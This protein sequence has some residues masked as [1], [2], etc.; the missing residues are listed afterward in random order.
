M[1][2]QR[3]VLV[4]IALVVM[5]GCS[6]LPGDESRTSPTPTGA[7]DVDRGTP[8]STPTPNESSRYPPGVNETT[9]E[10]VSALLAAHTTVLNQTGYVA[11]GSGNTTIIRSG[12]LL[13]VTR[14]GRVVVSEGSRRYFEVRRT[15]AGP[16]N[17]NNQRY[18][19]DSVEFRRNAEDGDVN[20]RKGPRQSAETLAR[21]D[22]LESYLLGGNFTVTDVDDNETPNTIVLEA[23]R[24]DNETALLSGLPSGAKR[25]V[26][27]NATAIVDSEGRV[28][29]LDATIEFVIGG[30]QR[31]HS[32]EFTLVRIGV[33]NVSEPDWV[34]EF[35]ESEGPTDDGAGRADARHRLLES[36]GSTVDTD[37]AS[38]QRS[39]LHRRAES[40]SRVPSR[41]D[42]VVAPSK[43]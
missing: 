11:N 12:F 36:G 8:S 24:S 14:E 33:S 31:T 1:T 21:V 28:R 16:V 19:N 13:D 5:A 22:Y 18:S 43:R 2:S 4:V 20:L 37:I 7:A 29:Q 38:G 3:R 26:S 25:I 10:N 30:E 27:Y 39:W 32:I 40:S 42:P 41:I 23:N 35:N 9:I 15:Q 34:G 6:A 17:R